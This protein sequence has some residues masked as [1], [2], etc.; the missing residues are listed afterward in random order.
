MIKKFFFI[1]LIFSLYGYAQTIDLPKG[2]NMLGATG[3]L[4]TSALISNQ[5]ERIW[6]YDAGVWDYYTT[7]KVGTIQSGSGFWLNSDTNKTYTLP[8]LAGSGK[9]WAKGWNLLSPNVT[10]WTLSANRFPTVSFGWRYISGEN[11][12]LLYTPQDNSYNFDK[13]ETVS[14]GQG[15]WFRSDTH[16]AMVGDS[17]IVVTNGDFGSIEKGK[18]NDF[19]SDVQIKKQELLSVVENNFNTTFSIDVSKSNT[20]TFQI[21]VKLSKPSTSESEYFYIVNGGVNTDI[22]TGSFEKP[23]VKL[24]KYPNPDNESAAG[25]LGVPDGVLTLVNNNYLKLNFNKIVE[26]L[27]NTNHKTT[28]EMINRFNQTSTYKYEIFATNLALLNSTQLTQTT[29]LAGGT[30]NPPTGT[31]KIEGIISVK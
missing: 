5:N 29:P 21:I 12:W 31:Y 30:Y 27:I 17:G 9:F 18:K 16:N 11:K 15:V 26:W 13:L 24:D 2:W 8:Q 3:E 19:S 23:Y 14:L 10:N 25:R 20:Q 28:D 1:G 6:V 22:G 4:S 7:T